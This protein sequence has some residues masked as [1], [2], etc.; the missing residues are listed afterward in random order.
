MKS[1]WNMSNVGL[2]VIVHEATR[3]D[4]EDRNRS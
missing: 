1:F 2:S 3:L 4:V